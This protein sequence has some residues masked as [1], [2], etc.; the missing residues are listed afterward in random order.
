MALKRRGAPPFAMGYS[1]AHK[2]KN[3]TKRWTKLSDSTEIGLTIS[4]NGPTF[5]E[6]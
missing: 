6:K 4:L 1:N 5:D 2:G 3:W